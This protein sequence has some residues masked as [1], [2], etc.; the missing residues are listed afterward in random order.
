[1][2]VD[3]D[4]IIGVNQIDDGGLAGFDYMMTNDFRTSSVNFT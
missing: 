1:M 4:K 2:D 3:I